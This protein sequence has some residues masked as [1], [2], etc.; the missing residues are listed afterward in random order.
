MFFGHDDRIDSVAR[1]PD[2]LDV[3]ALLAGLGEPG[4]FE[5]ALDLAKGAAA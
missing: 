2:E 1:V 3:A 5:P 4:R